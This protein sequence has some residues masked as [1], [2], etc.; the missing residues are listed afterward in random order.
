M[1]SDVD[2]KYV[3]PKDVYDMNI[4]TMTYLCSFLFKNRKMLRSFSDEYHKKINKNLN[5]KTPYIC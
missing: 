1:L 2:L 5:K 3:L 4:L